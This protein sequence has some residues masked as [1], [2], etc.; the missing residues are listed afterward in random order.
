MISFQPDGDMFTREQINALIHYA[1]GANAEDSPALSWPDPMGEELEEVIFI[2]EEAK[3]RY[4]SEELEKARADFIKERKADGSA[5][6]DEIGRLCGL[7]L[8]LLTGKEY[9]EPLFELE[10]ACFPLMSEVF[11]NICYFL[12]GSDDLIFIPFGEYGFVFNARVGGG[13]TKPSLGFLSYDI[14]QGNITSE[15]DTR[16]LHKA[17]GAAVFSYFLRGVETYCTFD[18]REQRRFMFPACAFFWS[19]LDSIREG[20][21]CVCDI[22]GSP[23]ISA[24]ER[25]K[26]AKYCSQTCQNRAKVLQRKARNEAQNAEECRDLI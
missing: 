12:E 7:A 19:A 18:G 8:G 22:C 21:A 9:K 15:E 20:R 5:A 1:S 3:R 23:F 26:K 2:P 13:R 25:G 14:Q 6:W 11:A 10:T 24:K 4:S 16:L 17:L